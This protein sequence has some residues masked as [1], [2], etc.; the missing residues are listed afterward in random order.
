MKQAQR[1]ITIGIGSSSEDICENLNQLL[2]KREMDDGEPYPSFLYDIFALEDGDGAGSGTLSLGKPDFKGEESFEELSSEDFQE[3]FSR[4]LRRGIEQISEASKIAQ[5]KASREIA[6]REE[7]QFFLLVPTSTLPGHENFFRVLKIIH[8]V[9]NERALPFQVR[10][11]LL[12]PELLPS[13]AREGSQ[14]DGA[15][16][17]ATLMELEHIMNDRASS[18]WND[19]FPLDDIWLID[20]YNDNKE[21][22]GDLSELSVSLAEAT[23][24]MIVEGV[25]IDDHKGADLK[26]QGFFY[27]SFGFTQLVFPRSILR[28]QIIDKTEEKLLSNHVLRGEE[29]PSLDEVVIKVRRFLKNDLQ[30]GDFLER[31]QHDAD[32]KDLLPSFQYE[33]NEELD[34]DDFVQ[35]VE[36]ESEAHEDKV[37]ATKIKLLE[38]AREVK[39]KVLQTIRIHTDDLIDSHKNGLYQALAFYDE[40]LGEG[41]E[42]NYTGGKLLEERR[43]LRTYFN[44]YKDEMREVLGLAKVEEDLDSLEERIRDK[45]EALK[46]CEQRVEKLEKELGGS[47]QKDGENGGQEGS[48]GEGNKS[49]PSNSAPS[50]RPTSGSKKES[51]EALRDRLKRLKSD[52]T[53]LKSERKETREILSFLDGSWDETENKK[54]LIKRRKK[55]KREEIRKTK[56][57]LLETDGELEGIN[58]ELSELKEAGG[59]FSSAW[60]VRYPAILI[61]FF[62]LLGIG[63]F[64]ADSFS[65]LTISNLPS[66]LGASSLIVLSI[67]YGWRGVKY[68][69]KFF[70]RM[71]E[72]RAKKT[73]LQE[74]INNLRSEFID[75]YRSFYNWVLQVWSYERLTSDVMSELVRTIKRDRVTIESF[76]NNCKEFHQ[77]LNEKEYRYP[78]TLSRT[79][80][81][82]EDDWGIFLPLL[83]AND[84][85][86]EAS[87]FFQKYAISEYSRDGAEGVESLRTVASEFAVDRF[88]NNVESIS[89]EELMFDFNDKLS[90][91]T[92]PENQLTSL[93]TVAPFLSIRSSAGQGNVKKLYDVGVEDA[94][95]SRITNHEILKSLSVSP[96]FFSH[97]DNSKILASCR[98]TN[99]S[100]SCIAR[101][102]ALRQAYEDYSEK[103]GAE[104]IHHDMFEE[105][106]LPKPQ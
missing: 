49:A 91:Q 81:I 10:A 28:E 46:D 44:D 55:R 62:A 68:Y 41:E 82:T 89:I 23:A 32:G 45:K 87:N 57:E 16:T 8:E 19:N 7:I 38:R 103:E 18:P 86:E 2:E 102:P 61:G 65:S 88:E 43:N 51:L 76:L 77:K 83:T 29:T 25:I 94:D 30:A 4:H 84:W 14:E 101:L 5:L 71:R 34:P 26:E 105:E 106:E 50:S 67:Y 36:E 20:K 70:S 78:E 17:Y 37:D 98:T 48:S 96:N 31:V 59:E 24:S 56:E 13:D 66:Y 104:N 85:R 73:K 79:S 9:C 12:M 21:S 53:N 22:V 90:Q 1:A 52:L 95:S 27:S 80:I 47:K 60:F 100:I 92:S 72:L 64:L 58:R 11:F 97:Y 3:E 15:R 39:E 6:V 74:K 63:L 35:A 33:V 93:L 42:S 54:A 69:D 99:F 75:Q 40:L